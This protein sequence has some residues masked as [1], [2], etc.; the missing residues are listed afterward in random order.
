LDEETLQFYRS[1]A[2]AYASREIAAHTRLTLY[3]ALLAPGVA[4]LSPP[5]HLWLEELELGDLAFGLAP[6][7]RLDQSSIDRDD[8]FG[9]PKRRTRSGCPLPVEKRSSSFRQDRSV[10]P[11]PR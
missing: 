6:G 10:R 1:N 4:P 2:E 7:P 9:G 8:V 5:L 3:L 11:E